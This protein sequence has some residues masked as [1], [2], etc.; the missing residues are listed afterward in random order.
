MRDYGFHIDRGGNVLLLTR[1]SAKG[2]PHLASAI[3]T[4]AVV[5]REGRHWRRS[6]SGQRYSAQAEAGQ[7]AA[8]VARKAAVE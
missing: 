2:R 1:P 7:W 3:P 5:Y 4:G 8:A 6:G